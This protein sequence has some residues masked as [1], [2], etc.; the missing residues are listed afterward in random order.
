VVNLKS[1][2][3]D[4]EG[5]V[6]GSVCVV[7]GAENAAALKLRGDGKT[8]IFHDGG[9]DVDVG[10]GLTVVDSAGKSAGHAHDK[11]DARHI[12]ICGGTLGKETVTAE[13]IAV[14]G[15]VHNGGVGGRGVNDLAYKT[16]GV[17]VAAEIVFVFDLEFLAVGV[18]LLRRPYLL[19]YRLALKRVVNSG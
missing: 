13:K 12:V 16:V 5:I 18:G 14:V 10:N 9:A 15:G 1:A 11:G 7:S 19:V 3:F 6:G 8:E 2:E 17:G 4:E